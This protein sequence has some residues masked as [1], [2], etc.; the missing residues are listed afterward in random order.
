MRCSFRSC[1]PRT[2]RRGSTSDAALAGQ[3]S[4]SAD[5]TRQIEGRPISPTSATT[6]R[7]AD[8]AHRAIASAT[9]LFIRQGYAG[10]SL[11]EVADRAGV[12]KSLLHY[13]FD[14]KPDLL[15]AVVS[16]Y[17]AETEDV[18]DGLE[19]QP[20]TT[21]EHVLESYRDVLLR[22][23]LAA[24][25]LN[26]DVTATA[27][28]VIG[29]RFRE[30]HARWRALLSSSPVAA[31]A[32]IGMLT[33]PVVMLANVP[34]DELAAHLGAIITSARAVVDVPPPGR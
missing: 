23:R 31:A 21:P 14:S 19:G 3:Y 33:R 25:L 11:Q 27:V 16:D 1:S 9:D 28:D 6:P 10:T 32:A 22:H 12:S 13:H 18:L 26:T 17:L 20:H 8:G 5:R 7:R 30:A 29:T 24:R 15:Q 4:T 34:D 2:P